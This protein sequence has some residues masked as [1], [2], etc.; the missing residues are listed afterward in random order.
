MCEDSKVKLLTMMVD[1]LNH[2]VFCN[3]YYNFLSDGLLYFYTMIDKSSGYTGNSNSFK[4][5]TCRRYG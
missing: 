5:Y 4:S 2:K 3:T 1:V